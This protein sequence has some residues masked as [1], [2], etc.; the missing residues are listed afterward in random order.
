MATIIDMLRHLLSGARPIDITLLAIELLVFAVIAGDAALRTYRHYKVRHRL[1]RLH[2][3]MFEGHALQDN[4]DEVS[5]VGAWGE[6]V[7]GWIVDTSKYLEQCS[8][9]ALESFL[10]SDNKPSV[11]YQGV[12][13]KAHGPYEV[14]Q[15]H[16]D[17]L[18]AIMERPDVYL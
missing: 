17:N 6:R 13:Y 3:F 7:N 15:E 8:S 11:S 14:L 9:Q 16:L 18:R 5:D 10:H 4:V 2:K 12:P 1:K